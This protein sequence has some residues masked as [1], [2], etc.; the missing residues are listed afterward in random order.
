MSLDTFYFIFL[1]EFL[2]LLG[3]LW[4]FSKWRYFA[5]LFISSAVL[6]PGFYFLFNYI[7]K[8][9]PGILSNPLVKLV[10][11]FWAGFLKKAVIVTPLILVGSVALALVYLFLL[12]PLVVRI[13][14][15]VFKLK[16]RIFDQE[17][18]AVKKTNYEVAQHFRPEKY[19][20]GLQS[21]TPIYLTEPEMTTHIQVVGPSGVGKT[22]SVLFPLATQALMKNTPLVFVDGKGDAKLKQMLWSF[23]Q[24]KNIKM[25]FFDPLQPNFSD[26]YNPLA[27]STDANELTNVLAV[28]L[29]LNAPGE[30][31]V[32]T[33]IQK[34]FLATLLHLFVETKMK[35]NFVDMVEFINHKLARVLVYGSIP[36][37]FYR[38][39]MLVFL[40]RLSKNEKELIGLATILDQ[41]FVSDERIS[42]IINTYEPSIDIRKIL[43]EGGAVLFSF[44]AGMKAQTNE[45]L[46]KMVLADI[47]NSV[48]MRHAD[49]SQEN[50]FAIVILDE[51]GQYVS[52]SFDK[53]ISTARS[54]N[55]SC[56]LSHQTN[57]QLETYFSRDR[58]ARVV[59]ENTAGKIIFRQQE[60]A[61]FW[62]ETF[63]TKSAMKRTEQV[64]TGPLLTERVSEMGTLREVDEFILHPN[65][66]RTL[67]VGQAVWK[68]REKE[69]QVVNLGTYQVPD[70][71]SPTPVEHRYGEG[72]D[73][74][75]KRIKAQKIEMEQVTQREKEIRKEVR[76]Y[77]K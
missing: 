62:A 42:E 36:D 68:F 29:N 40:A 51:F 35:F 67:K 76:E 2:L 30:A 44:S 23:C 34:K 8:L 46:A 64:E 20:V 19:F 38:D 43:K 75:S 52:E 15:L 54:A 25:H 12:R 17:E 26:S 66:L 6:L 33:D 59:R 10:F 69:P 55:I 39:E 71:F 63:G 3:F 32:Y 50:K 73:L 72:L 60:E 57:A 48:G 14:E 28:G 7:K 21:K 47:A 18:K 61:S 24:A 65:L 5:S 41:L 27:G 9:N 31:K 58:L 11:P 53:F 16:I 37:Q 49:F 77:I 4:W 56:V 22:V 45:A 70:G 74:R 1:I 13:N